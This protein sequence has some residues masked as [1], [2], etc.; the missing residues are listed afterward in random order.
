VFGRL[1]A[2]TASEMFRGC[3]FVNTCT[4]LADSGHPAR[5]VARDY[6]RRIRDYF[7]DQAER[8]HAEDPQRLADQLAVVFDGAIVQ[9]VAGAMLDPETI[10]SAVL[11][12]LDAQGLR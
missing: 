10:Q 4:E 9:A 3:A 6:K 12:L 11:A 5:R 7:A 8:G 1:S 2:W